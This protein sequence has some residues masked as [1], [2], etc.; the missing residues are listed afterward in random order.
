MLISLWT[1]M[2]K[3]LWNIHCGP[4]I[5]INQQFEF[6]IGVYSEGDF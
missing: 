6:D 3:Q 2:L 1:L 5:H 4:G